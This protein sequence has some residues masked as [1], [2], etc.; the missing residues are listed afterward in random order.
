MAEGTYEYECMRAELLGIDPPNYEDYLQKKKDE[1]EAKR[2]AQQHEEAE[3]ENLK[4]AEEQGEELKGTAGKLDELNSILSATQKKIDRF[5]V[6]CGSVTE[7]IKTKIGSISSNGESKPQEKGSSSDQ[8]QEE[9]QEEEV[10]SVVA[11]ASGENPRKSD[12]AKALDNHVDKLDTLL[13]KADNAQ[14]SMQEQTKKMKRL[15]R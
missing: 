5:K 1:E 4:A 6:R 8:P 9:Q 12:L 7:L 2:A 11:E 14:Y 15:L 3:V 13:D 10:E